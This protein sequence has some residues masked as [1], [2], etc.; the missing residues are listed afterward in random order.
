[1][2]RRALLATLLVLPLAACG[3]GPVVMPEAATTL[4][5]LR[6][7]DRAGEELNRKGRARAAALPGA[8]AGHDIA[9]IYA[10]D[11]R[12]NLATAEPLARARG[13]EPQI[14]GRPDPTARLV[15][16]AAGQT[17]VWIGNKDNLRAIWA[18]LDAPGH[19][20][21]DYGEIAVLGLSA[22]R[23]V[24]VHRLRFDP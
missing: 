14:I 5:L 24:S 17:A 16:A 9:G 8:L 11:L 12:R 4:I 15:R 6:H 21:L 19:P 1:M 10:P 22:E 20:P 13:L 3:T 2:H 18:R 7:A 23:P